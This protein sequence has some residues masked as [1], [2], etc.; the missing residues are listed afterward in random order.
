MKET[1]SEFAP[2]DLFYQDTSMKNPF[3]VGMKLESVDLMNSHQICVATVSAVSNR[4]IRLSFDG[5]EQEFD[6]WIDCES[7]DIYP[8]GWCKMTGYVLQPP[9]DIQKKTV[10]QARKRTYSKKTKA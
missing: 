1:N 5:W 10:Q 4:L 9:V 2:I 8:V 7:S 3:K 6:Q